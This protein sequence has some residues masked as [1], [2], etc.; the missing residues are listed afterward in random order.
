MKIVLLF[1]SV[2]TITLSFGQFAVVSDRDG[3]VNVRSSSKTSGRI[4]DTLKNG[5]LIYCFEAE[6][7]WKSIDYTKRKQE[8]NGYIY[9]DRFKFISD[10]EEIPLSDRKANSSIYSKDS[11]KIIVS[12]KQFNRANYHFSYHKDA[13]DQIEFMNG[14]QYW[15]TD[16]GQP[17]TEYNFILVQLDSKKIYLPQIA[18]NNLFEP[19]IHHTQVHY[20]RENDTLYIHA[21]NSD[22]AGGYEVIWKIEKSVYKERFIVHGF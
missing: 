5:H 6:G 9:T 15:G 11:L 1:L 22:G 19:N 16:G 3:Y 4:T 8:M 2:F 18:L 10:Y 7:N 14:K 13:K 12:K 17:K 20:D 21:M